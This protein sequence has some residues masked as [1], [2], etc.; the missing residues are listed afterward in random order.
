MID[1]VT[2]SALISTGGA[3]LGGIFDRRAQSRAN[4]ANTPYA[5]VKSWEKAGINPLVGITQGQYIPQQANS[6]GDLFATAGGIWGDAVANK[7]EAKLRETQLELQNQLLKKELDATV[8][9]REPSA[10]QRFGGGLP[11]ADEA[12]SVPVL[13]SPEG[14]ATIEEG[15]PTLSNVADLDGTFYSKP[16]V[17]DAAIWAERYGEPGEILG[18]LHVAISDVEYNSALASAVKNSKFTAQELHEGFARGDLNMARVIFPHLRQYR[19][20][21]SI[22]DFNAGAWHGAGNDPTWP[23]Q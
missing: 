10:M 6:I 19:D 1:P 8:E 14:S 16:N 18:A 15:I 12:L 3:F 11:L 4:K 7:P 21:P 13:G 5:Q 23:M 2:A 22:G 17:K 9:P 20:A